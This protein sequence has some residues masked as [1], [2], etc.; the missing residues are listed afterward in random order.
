MLEAA[1]TSALQEAGDNGIIAKTE[2]GAYDYSVTFGKRAD[3]DAGDRAERVY[4][5]GSFRFALAGAVHNVE[6]TG[7][8][9]F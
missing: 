7:E 1:A 3:T 9:T 2:D 5:R 6:V 8:I 4:K